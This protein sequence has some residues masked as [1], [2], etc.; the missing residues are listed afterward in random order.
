M[1]TIGGSLNS[2]L[3][4]IETSGRIPPNLDTAKCDP[5]EGVAIFDLTDL[6]WGSFFNPYAPAYQVPQKV[7]KVIGGT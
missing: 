1:L 3:Y 6:V 5:R 7:V 2:S 4:G